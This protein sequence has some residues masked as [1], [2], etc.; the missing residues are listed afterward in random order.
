MN[1]GAIDYGHAIGEM[2]PYVVRDVY[3]ATVLPEDLGNYEP[4]P[5]YIFPP[6]SVADV[7]NDADKEAVIRDGFAAFYYHPFYGVAPLQQIVDGLRA[8]GWTFASPTQVAGL[9]P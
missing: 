9:T 8:R 4:Q 5:F 1:G 6:H 7:L 3:G 2:F